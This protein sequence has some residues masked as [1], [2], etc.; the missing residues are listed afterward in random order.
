M[1]AVELS[2]PADESGDGPGATDTPLS[3][4]AVAAPGELGRDLPLP[5][6][7]KTVFLGGL[8][9][10]AVLVV[11][12]LAV[13][14]ILP[15]IIAIILKL[16]LQPIVR[17]LERLWVPRM[18]AAA[19]A[20]LL[21][22]VLLVGIGTLIS[23]PAASWFSRLPETGH[24]LQERLSA[25]R[26]PM[27]LVDQQLKQIDAWAKTGPSPTVVVERG[28]GAAETIFTG[29]RA[30]LGIIMTSLLF[31]FFLLF[32]GDLFLRRAVEILPRFRDKRQVVSI[33]QQIEQDVSAYLVTITI[34]NLLVGVA[35]TV[36]TYALGLSDPLLWGAAAFLLNY[37]P[38]LGPAAGACLFL[39]VGLLSF[40]SLW[41][42]FLPAG[43]YIVIHVIEGQAITP[44]L[45]AR[46]F[47]LNPVM[48][49]FAIVFWYWMWGVPG[50]VLAVPML[51]ITKIVCDRIRSLSAFGHFLGGNA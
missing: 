45:L 13:D 31:L 33:A 25:L 14:I 5:S 35:T 42:A 27:Q 16:L 1:S 8:L 48:V 34:M 51:A 30:V 49:I 19:L 41:Q 10:L 46:R 11:A 2:E 23:A 21:V 28:A 3:A 20:V 18:L 22:V 29:T 43:G 26:A 44:M 32:S 36:V 15:V 24:K 47:T 50:A 17:G 40:D 37:L 7:P 4:D 12:Y 6:D 9:L 38:I 39:L